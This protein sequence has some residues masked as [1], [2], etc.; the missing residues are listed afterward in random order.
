MTRRVLLTLVVIAFAI[1]VSAQPIPARL[2]FESGR[3]LILVTGRINGSRAL[4]L[5]LDTGAGISVIDSS[6]IETLGLKEVGA[7][8]ASGA[9]G[10]AQAK[11]LSGAKLTL[12]GVGD[13]IDLPMIGLPIKSLETQIGAPVDGILGREFFEKFVVTID[14]RDRWVEFSREA[15]PVGRGKV[16]PF[17]LERGIPVIAATVELGDGRKVATT[18]GIDTGANRGVTLHADFVAANKVLPFPGPSIETFAGGVGG[19]RATV[20]GRLGAIEFGGFRI[21]RPIAQATPA[22]VRGSVETAER[23]GLLGF[24]V[25]RK[26]RM[27]VDYGRGQL[28]LEPNADFESAIEA[29]M[30]GLG[31]AKAVTGIRI[32]RVSPKSPAE[33]LGIKPGDVLVEVDGKSAS[34]LGLTRL[35]DMFRIEGKTYALRLERGKES[36]VVSLK[37]R[38]LL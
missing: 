7:I 10:S 19:M 35:E 12:D 11:T 28:V 30:S 38:R 3:G 18:F 29:D 5:I 26:F 37:T 34:T 17:K 23:G 24:E 15:P 1:G 32:A 16:V 13:P 2:P 36:R 21:P 20:M 8:T 6:L 27:V 25:F 4:N 31:L 22:P 14:Y 33:A 9:G